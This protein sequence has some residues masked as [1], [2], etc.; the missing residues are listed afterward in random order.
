MGRH[1]VTGHALNIIFHVYIEQGRTDQRTLV[2]S[3]LQVEALTSTPKVQSIMHALQE[4][5]FVVGKYVF[6]LQDRVEAV[7]IDRVIG[8]F[9]V[10]E[11]DTF[12]LMFIE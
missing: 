1:T 6:L 8:R 2:N 9:V 4:I 11:N 12:I 3:I 5:H 10:Y 7:A